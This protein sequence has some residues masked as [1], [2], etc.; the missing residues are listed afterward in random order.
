[1]NP[2]QAAKTMSKNATN[3]V[4][5]QWHS[6][7]S[8]EVLYDE[9]LVNNHLK[10]TTLAIV[11]AAIEYH[12][13]ITCDH[14]PKLDMDYWADWETDWVIKEPELLAGYLELVTERRLRY[15]QRFIGIKAMI[16]LGKDF[17]V[18]HGEEE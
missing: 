6:D 14:G 3:T 10:W 5:L 11:M 7:D 4:W 8:I 16:D 12:I 15:R 9:A 2:D 17:I 18:S 1:M 13:S